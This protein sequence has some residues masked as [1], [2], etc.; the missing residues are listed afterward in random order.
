[1]SSD[2]LPSS[3]LY[4]EISDEDTDK[5]VSIDISFRIIRQFSLEL[6]DN[7]RRAIEELVCNSYDANASECYVKTPSDQ[8]ESLYVLDDG[9]SMSMDGLEWLWKVAASRKEQELDEDREKGGR[10]QIGKFGVGKLAAFALGSRLTYVATKEGTTRVVSVHQARLKNENS[11]GAEDFDVYE[12]PSD[13]AEERIGQYFNEVPNP[14]DEDWDSWTLAIISDIPEENTGTDLRPWHLKNMIQ[15]AIP[16][17][18]DF[19]TYLNHEQISERDVHGEQIYSVDVTDADVIEKIED[20]IQSYWSSK[21]DIDR[22]DVDPSMYEIEMTTFPNPQNTSESLASIDVPKLGHV[23]G[24]GQLYDRPITTDKRKERGFQDNGFRVRVRGKLINKD[25][26]LFGLEPL[27]HSTWAQFLGEFEMPGLDQ[28]IRVH[29][30]DLKDT[31]KVDIAQIVLRRI[32]N[33]VRNKHRN[34]TEEDEDHSITPNPNTEPQTVTRSFS[35]RLQERSRP[36]A[37]D[38]PSL[39]KPHLSVV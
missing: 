8:S 4:K 34:I 14:W 31:P 38:H 6:Y 13:E 19:T 12:F 30:D 39:A 26:P 9:H 18:T 7:P 11:S 23:A 29:R 2:E 27:S 33:N 32:F 1:M 25:A 24:S 36:Y 17:S 22:E 5:S 20:K 16:T 15:T 21:R 10:Q 37:R 35:E 3:E 28:D